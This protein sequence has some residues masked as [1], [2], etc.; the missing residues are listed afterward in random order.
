MAWRYQR[1]RENVDQRPYW[2]YVAV[3]NSHTRSSHASRHGRVFR[4]DDAGWDTLF[5]PNGYNL[6][7]PGTGGAGG[8]PACTSPHRTGVHRRLSRHG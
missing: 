1:L 7:L 5:P 6:P 3:I 4:Y 8:R 2:Q